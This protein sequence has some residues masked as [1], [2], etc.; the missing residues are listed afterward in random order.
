M[1]SRIFKSRHM[2]NYFALSSTSRSA[3]S[4]AIHAQVPNSDE[5]QFV[6]PGRV[7]LVQPAD[8]IGA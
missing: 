2:H 8:V 4:R 7:E 6:F 5:G 3:I 1:A